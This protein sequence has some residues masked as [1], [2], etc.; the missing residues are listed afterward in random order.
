MSAESLYAG[1]REAL[2]RKVNHLQSS[3]HKKI[4]HQENAVLAGHKMLCLQ[5]RK[6]LHVSMCDNLMLEAELTVME[7]AGFARDARWD[8]LKEAV[9]A[10]VEEGRVLMEKQEQRSLEEFNDD[11]EY[12]KMLQEAV[13]V[14]HCRCPHDWLRRGLTEI[15]QDG[16][17]L[18][19]VVAGGGQRVKLHMQVGE[20]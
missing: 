7:K 11:S 14:M 16:L 12:F 17:G 18:A 4:M 6:T 3:T 5:R 1:E 10:A 15:D 8:E 2:A 9:E 13:Q 19:L 20:N